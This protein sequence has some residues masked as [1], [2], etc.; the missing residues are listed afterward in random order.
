MEPPLNLFQGACLISGV[1]HQGRGE[2]PQ[3]VHSETLMVKKSWWLH[4]TQGPSGW[5]FD[6][7]LQ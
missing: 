7:Q 1:T 6:K 3:C 4:G 2:H 5:K